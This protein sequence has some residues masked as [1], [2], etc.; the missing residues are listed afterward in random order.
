MQPKNMIKRSQKH[1]SQRLCNGTVASRCN[2]EK[3]ITK[4]DGEA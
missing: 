1:I 2:G 3:I 4:P